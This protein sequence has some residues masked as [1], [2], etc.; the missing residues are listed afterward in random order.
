MTAHGVCGGCDRTW[1]A[2]RA[3]HCPRCHRQFSTD[4]N[5]SRHLIIDAGIVTGCADP[6]TL[7]HPLE[8]AAGDVWRSPSGSTPAHWTRITPTSQS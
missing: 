5:Y 1:T 3:S 6:T 4:S 7:K 2:E 8:Q